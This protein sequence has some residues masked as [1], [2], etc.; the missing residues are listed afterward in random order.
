VIAAEAFSGG[1]PI[2]P[3]SL[4]ASVTPY[5]SIPMHEKKE[6]RVALQGSH[7]LVEK[8]D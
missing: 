2:K 3:I 4:Y 5:Q 6:G 7:V 8:R 1:R